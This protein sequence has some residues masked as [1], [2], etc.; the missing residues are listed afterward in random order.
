MIGRLNV[1]W[2]ALTQTSAP[3]RTP[4]SAA[5]SRTSSRSAVTRSD[6][7]ARAADSASA[8][9]RSATRIRSNRPPWARSRTVHR[10]V[11]PPPPRTTASILGPRGRRGVRYL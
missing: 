8:R 9:S 4:R 7:V 3:F 1:Y 6:P 5:A 2:T 10:P 11:R